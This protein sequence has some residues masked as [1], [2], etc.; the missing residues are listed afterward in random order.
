MIKIFLTIVEKHGLG[1]ANLALLV[2]V[3]WK[4][5]TNHFKHL[6][7]QVNKMEKTLTT[8]DET[9]REIGERVATLEGKI[10]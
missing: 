1:V 4:F 9:V 2:Y 8:V 6:T 7:D 5:A 3:S 10:D